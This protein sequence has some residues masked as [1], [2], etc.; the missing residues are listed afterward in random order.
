MQAE[1]DGSLLI[2]AEAAYLEALADPHRGIRTAQTLAT[3]ARE[4]GANEALVVALR[5]A[6]SA[7]RELYQHDDA[8]RF[9]GE[10][11]RVSREAGL[12][13]RLCEVLITSSSTHIELGRPQLAQRDLDE[14]RAV[15]SDRTRPWV[16][17]AEGLLEDKA[18]NFA[19]AA[20]AYR[21]A[22]R[23]TGKN[24]PTLRVKALNNLALT[25]VRFGLYDEAERLLEEAIELAA[26]RL[27]AREGIAT[28]SLA[29]VAVESGR[30]VDALRRYERAEALLTKFGVQLVDLYLGK[31]KAL[32][33][34]HLLDEAA[35]A[36]ARAVQQV[37][38]LAGGSLMLAEALL[39]QAQIAL[40]RNRR[41]EAIAA[42][43]RAEQL[44]RRQRRSGWRATAALLRLSGQAQETPTPSMTAQLDRIERT[45]SEIG[46]VPGAIE[47]AMLQG[48]VSAAL[49]R[50]RKAT[51]AFGRA[52]AAAA[53]G[54]GLL[55]LQGR[56]AAAR[57]AE[58]ENDTRR[59]GQI[60]RLGL[61]E[62]AAYRA[63]VVSVELRA[64]AAAHGMTLAA[65]G[66]RAALR[67]GRPEQIWAWLERA[68]SVVFIRGAQ[69]RDEQLRP[70]L[71]ELRS[72]ER[73]LADLPPDVAAERGTLLRR[74]T[75]LER[76]IRS[77]SWTRKGGH[78]GWTSPSVRRLRAL[79]TDLGE[80]ALLQYGVLEGRLFGVVV[81]RDRVWFTELGA[82]NVV[83]DSGRQLAFA[84]R[85]LS[86]PRSR[87]SAAA[88]FD[89]ARHEL[90]R[91]AAMLLAPLAVGFTEAVEVIVAP[92]GELIGVPWG[93]LAPLADRPVRVVP[94][95]MAWWYSR[96]TTP[97]SDRV[98]LVAGPG[99]VGAQDEV[100]AIARIHVGAQRFTALAARSEDVQRAA[101][102]ARLVHV[103]AHGRLRA[104]SPTFSSLHLADGPLT[105]HDLEGLE[106]PA[107]HWILAACD[108]GHPG[109][110]A[111]PALEGVLATLLSSG[112]GAVVAAVASVPDLSTR[113]L[114][115][116]LHE[117]LAAGLPMPESLRRASRTLDTND[118]AGFVAATAFSC[119]GGG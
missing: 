115:V 50:R 81:A 48:E 92:P 46:N 2:Q 114:M 100:D 16:D 91:L 117:Y 44:F 72:L 23:R 71:A 90:R 17:F 62:L 59:L 87:A 99:L 10:A 14:A 41:A 43:A 102:G 107:H 47:A 96:R 4:A 32:L 76:H 15:A 116:A 36:A 39:P 58:L 89:S 60:C 31:A 7:A 8:Q 88:A 49:G 40:A 55:R 54:P 64:R 25:V 95:A 110:L 63:T 98:V 26:T 103:A 24:N 53:S 35:D 93:A 42:A 97:I 75:R 94:S 18:G 3:S 22:L 52:A 61:D 69:L 77:A 78:D 67:A 51:A 106:A 33:T 85:R 80:R 112:V 66:L 34:L 73:Q 13:D 56:R 68:R 5:A 118:P 70:L 19:S 57:K 29:I 82:V 6:G 38:G 74:I 84:L 113:D 45:M 101:A 83:V 11:A 111:G 28:E 109:A 21:R 12:H 20:D 108:L 65:I 37:E 1:P 9:L 27:P 86:Q 119:Y 79:R 105:V 104:D 30:P